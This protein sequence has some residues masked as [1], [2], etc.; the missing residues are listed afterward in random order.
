MTQWVYV[1]KP[2]RESVGVGVFDTAASKEVYEAMRGRARGL[3]TQR[4]FVAILPTGDEVRVDARDHSWTVY[5]SETSDVSAD[6]GSL[7]FR[8][9]VTKAKGAP[10]ACFDS[11]LDEYAL[12][13]SR[14]GP[15][16][17]SRRTYSTGEEVF[18]VAT[19]GRTRPSALE[20]L[21]TALA[22]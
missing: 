18:E 6:G 12:E 10:L 8:E 11:Y 15:L 16:R 7:V 1:A 17:L 19:T 21:A 14:A 20:A 13:E 9:R 4:F 2:V 5:T 22:H 3:R